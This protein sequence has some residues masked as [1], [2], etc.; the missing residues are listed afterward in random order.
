MSDESNELVYRLL[1][2]HKVEHKNNSSSPKSVS[3]PN[4]A[5]LIQPRNISFTD[6]M[7]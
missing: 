7:H 3:M 4:E 6:G 2:L 1:D 5:Q